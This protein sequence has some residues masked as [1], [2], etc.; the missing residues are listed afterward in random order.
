MMG[1]RIKKVRRTFNL[2]QQEFAER[3][4]IKRNTVAKYETN[5]GEPIGAV[6]SLICREFG[7]SEEWLRYGAGGMKTQETFPDSSE[8]NIK[9]GIK[10]FRE[11]KHLSQEELAEKIGVSQDA[12]SMYERGEDVP[13][14]GKLICLANVLEVSPYDLFNP[15][16]LFDSSTTQY[17]KAALTKE[18]LQV[19][20]AYRQA[21]P[22]DKQIFDIIADK[23]PQI[24]PPH[25]TYDESDIRAASAAIQKLYR[26]QHQKRKKSLPPQLDPD[27]IQR[28]AE[29][30]IDMKSTDEDSGKK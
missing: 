22:E 17:R 29:K 4:G 28:A 25:K 3:I 1:E 27:A 6:V 15:W 11:L 16:L 2:T 23:Y 18:E 13:D 21:T 24:E 26:E 8:I 5:R 20:Y 7:I 30:F 19:A 10:Y 14:Y 9:E 12:L